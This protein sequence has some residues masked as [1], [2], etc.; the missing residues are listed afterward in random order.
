MT[1]GE[2]GP[3]C[4]GESPEFSGIRL[5]IISIVLFGPASAGT[6][7]VEASV[8]LESRGMLALTGG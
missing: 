4:H 1:I 5:I 3:H 8:L 7:K 2:G 6:I